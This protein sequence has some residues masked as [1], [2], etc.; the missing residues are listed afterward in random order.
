MERVDGRCLFFFQAEDG[1]R[2]YKVTGVQTC[3]LPIC[4]ELD[5]HTIGRLVEANGAILAATSQGLYRHSTAPATFSDA[6]TPVLR[7]GVAPLPS[8]C[9]QSGG[10]SNHAFVSDVAVK[11]GTNGNVV[12]AVVG[13]RAGSNCNGIYE[14]T[15]GGATFSPVTVTGALNEGDMGRT[16][17]AYSATGSKVYPLVQSAG[18]FH[19]ARPDHGGTLLQGIL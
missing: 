14:S 18:L 15:N 11:P 2:D 8:A 19:H 7:E 4:N 16:T 13:W 17:I 10:V 6:W 3:A 1:I 12:D 9:S 5:N